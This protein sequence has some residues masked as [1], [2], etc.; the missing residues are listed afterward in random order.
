MLGYIFVWQTTALAAMGP[1]RPHTTD[2]HRYPTDTG[3]LCREWFCDD[4]VMK[5]ECRRRRKKEGKGE[6]KTTLTCNGWASRAALSTGASDRLPFCQC[7]V[8]APLCGA[9][10]VGDLMMMGVG[11]F[12][13]ASRLD[14]HF[15]V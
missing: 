8:H 3:R 12:V 2:H 6:M 9:L 15:I 13:Y 5:Y 7:A 4:A 1:E 14:L 11:G 10:L